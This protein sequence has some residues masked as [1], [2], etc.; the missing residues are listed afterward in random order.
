[1]YGAAE[2]YPPG[3]LAHD[4]A[5]APATLY[6]A[7]KVCD[8]WLA[9]VYAADWGIHSIGLRPLTVYGP[10]RDQGV[11][12]SPT[13]GMLAAAAG[14]PYHIAWGGVTGYGY[15]EDVASAFIAAALAADDGGPA[16][17]YNLPVETADMSEVL[18]AIAEAVP[19]VA[20]DAEPQGLPFAAA[21]DATETYGRLG[22]IPRTRLREGISR[23][24]DAFRQAIAEGRL[25]P[26]PILD[27]P[28]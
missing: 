6:G 19:G 21:F 25:D 3:P 14:R 7:H 4:A 17:T 26:A 22:T 9:R 12:S 24:V 13:L 10:G 1:V 15:T 18:E 27:R 5:F 23:T 16:E 28:A 8:E 11:T 2:L 20:V